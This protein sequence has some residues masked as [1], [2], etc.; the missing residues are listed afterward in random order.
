LAEQAIAVL[1]R[2]KR[3]ENAGVQRLVKASLD[4]HYRQYLRI[5]HKFDDPE[6]GPPFSP[7]PETDR[8]PAAAGSRY[9]VYA[10]S[11]E[12]RERLLVHDDKEMQAELVATGEAIDGIITEIE[13]EKQGRVTRVYWTVESDGTL[14]LRLRE[15]QS[16]CLIGCDRRHVE[17]LDIDQ[18]DQKTNRFEL[19]VTKGKTLEEKGLLRAEDKRLVGRRVLLVEPPMDGISRRKS[20]AIWRQDGPGHWITHAPPK[21]P[22]ADLPDDVAENLAEITRR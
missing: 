5:E 22:G 15:G 3:R 20:A 19:E 18:P 9:Y 12:L 13:A 1:Q 4:E 6:D 14:P 16:L 8:H 2:D 21:G 17:I 11:A 10:S 7:S